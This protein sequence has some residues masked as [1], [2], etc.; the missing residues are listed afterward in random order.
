[1]AGAIRACPTSASQRR[2]HRR[3]GIPCSRQALLSRKVLADIDQNLSEDLT[4]KKRYTEAGHVLLF[5]AKD[6]REA[7][8]VLTHGNQFSEARRIVSDR[9]TAPPKSSLI[10][11]RTT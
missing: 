11:S 5:Y 4:S 8:I 2:G 6:V 10:V 9:R 1:M 3:N 7:V